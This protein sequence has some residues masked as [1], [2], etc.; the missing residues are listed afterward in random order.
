MKI[1]IVG[2]GIAGMTA[3]WHL[4]RRHDITVFEGADYIGGHTNTIDVVHGGREY[5]IDTGFIVFNDQT[6]PEF[7]R[8]MD[9]LEVASQPTEMSF[10]VRCEATGIEYNGASLNKTFAQRRNLLRPSFHRMLSDILRFYREAPRLLA[11][12]NSTGPSLGE[13]LESNHYSGEFIKRHIMPLGSAIWSTDPSA[14][15]DFPAAL[16]LR[17]FHNHGLL[18]MKDRPQWRVI[19]GGSARYVEKLTAPFRDRI[20]LNTRVD[21]IRRTANS[22]EVKTRGAW[23]R[24]DSIAIASHGDHALRM[25]ADPSPIE[26]EILG[27]FR[28]QSNAT[29]LHT[30]D[31]VLPRTRRARAAWNYHL[32]SAEDQRVAITYNMN[33]LQRID[34]PVNF[35]V[36]LNHSDSIDPSKIIKRINYE[37]P[38]YD[39][40]AIAAQKR[41]AEV[42]GVNR[43]YY[44]GAY[45]GYG[46]HEDGVKSA[47]RVCAMIRD[48]AALNSRQ[49]QANAMRDQSRWPM[50]IAS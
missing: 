39:A 49:A 24:F 19:S 45:W 1:A 30:D 26:R 12:E 18:Q 40:K 32:I 38:V 23:E 44:C 11:V 17:F 35:C 46:F 5:S 48:A 13:Y 34:A 15:F 21:S 9:L 3:A 7:V 14:M 41:H 20:K 31:S 10:S 28:T 22:V 4:H 2:T 8:L 16:F 6:Y 27:S 50:E 37:H 36:T 47:L 42:N 29:V 43:T 25:L 33:V